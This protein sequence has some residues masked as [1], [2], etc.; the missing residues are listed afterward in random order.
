MGNQQS[1]PQ[2]YTPEQYKQYLEYQEQQKRLSNTSSVVANTSQRSINT[3]PIINKPQ[4]IPEP[5]Q[6]PKPKPIINKGNNINTAYNNQQNGRTQIK[7]EIKN[8]D[9][10]IIPDLQQKKNMPSVENHY[11]DRYQ[12]RMMDN[13][14]IGSKTMVSGATYTGLD[15]NNYNSQDI[16][17]YNSKIMQVPNTFREP[18]ISQLQLDREAIFIKKEKAREEE[19]IRVQE[20]RIEEEQRRF[21]QEQGNRR[22]QFNVELSEIENLKYNP[23]EILGLDKNSKHDVNDIKKAYRNLALRYHPDKGGSEEI[24]K[25]L[26]KA[27]IFLLKKTEKDNYVEKSFFDLKTQGQNDNNESAFIDEDF[28]VSHFNSIFDNNKLEDIEMDTGYGEW[29]QTENK[30]VKNEK[31]EKIFNQKFNLDIFNKVF[32]ELKTDTPNKLLEANEQITIY[33][34]PEILPIGAGLQYSDVDYNKIGDYSKEFNVNDNTK[35]LFFTDYKKAHT[36]TTLINPNSV[37]KR[38]Q[39]K[40]L[41]ELKSLRE[42]QNFTMTDD[43]KKHIE[44]KKHIEEEKEAQ[45]LLRLRQRDEQLMEHNSKVNKLL[46]GSDKPTQ[47]RQL[48]FQNN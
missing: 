46:L 35:G 26:T 3:T 23:E 7:P 44:M 38:E 21:K 43:E 6:T 11:Q 28:D 36:N 14:S 45:R 48:K 8:P 42:K 12:Q 13:L 33:K 37:N 5:Q 47:P 19:F 39:Y 4:S 24:F 30:N 16:H 1:N 40:D 20:K 29:M 34:E 9:N 41:E 15:S 25:I 27:Y 22:K 32:D 18:D 10:K 2:E 17:K 31:N